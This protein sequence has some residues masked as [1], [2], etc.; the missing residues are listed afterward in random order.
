MNEKR[1]TILNWNQSDESQN[2]LKSVMTLAGFEV[3]DV[4]SE[5][6]AINLVKLLPGFEDEI[7]CFLIRCTG[8]QDITL[9]ILKTLAT[10]GFTLPILLVASPEQEKSFREVQDS[11]PEGLNVHFCY[12]NSTLDALS[13]IAA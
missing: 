3:R 6:E 7:I 13:G 4:Y 10:G 1:Q 9:E 11:T 5:S 8:N 12:A 2:N